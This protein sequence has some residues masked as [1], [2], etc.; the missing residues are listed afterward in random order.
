M[1]YERSL[2]VCFLELFVIFIKLNFRLHYWTSVDFLGNWYSTKHGR[3]ET[4]V[5][6][7]NQ[8]TDHM[9]FTN[10]VMTCMHLE[11]SYLIAVGIRLYWLSVGNLQ[12]PV[13]SDD[14]CDIFRWETNSVQNHDHSDQTCLRNACCPNTGCS[15]SYTKQ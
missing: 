11:S 12:E 13:N 3:P 2:E 15:C 7:K 6:L 9:D 10:P 8:D 14:E 5:K 1:Q 4:Q